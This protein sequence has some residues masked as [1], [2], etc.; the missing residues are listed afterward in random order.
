MKQQRRTGPGRGATALCPRPSTLPS[1]ALPEAPPPPGRTSG[2]NSRPPSQSQRQT[3]AHLGTGSPHPRNPGTPRRPPAAR[4]GERG[5]SAARVRR[6]RGPGPPPHRAGRWSGRAGDARGCPIVLWSCR[7]LWGSPRSLRTP[8]VL[9]VTPQLNP[10]ALR[11]H[12][13]L[14]AGCPRGALR[15]ARVVWCNGCAR[16]FWSH[17]R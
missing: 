9:P 5:P 2:L 12:P 14:R 6:M 1:Q 15:A 17:L 11:E 4:A 3:R 8:P 13:S 10:S 7:S 16:R